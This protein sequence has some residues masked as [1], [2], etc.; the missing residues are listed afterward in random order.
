MLR[1]PGGFFDINW[2]NI[3]G[4]RAGYSDLLWKRDAA[5][6][7]YG[8][9][10][11]LEMLEKITGYLSE[12]DYIN[13]AAMFNLYWID[14]EY[15]K[16]DPE[17]TKLWDRLDYSREDI[18][19][20]IRK[21]RKIMGKIFEIYRKLQDRGQIEI[22]ASPYSHPMLSLLA[23]F[24]WEDDA[25][26]HIRKGIELYE[27][28][29]VAKPLGMWPPELAVNEASLRLMAEEG[30]IWT[31]ADMN[32]LQLAGIDIDDPRNL[33]IPYEVDLGNGKSIY[34]FFRDTPLSNQVSFAY[35]GWET[36]RAVEDF[37][38]RLLEV[39]KHNFDGKMTFTIALDGENPWE[40]YPNNANDFLHAL[41]TELTE[42]QKN[43]LIRTITPREYLRIFTVDRVLPKTEQET[44]DLKDID[45]SDIKKYEDLPRTRKLQAIPEGTWSGLALGHMIWIGDKQEDVAWMWLKAAR[46]TFMEFMKTHPEPEHRPMIKSAREALYLAQT[47]CWWF[48]YSWEMG[49]PVTFDPLFKA[50]LINIYQRLGEGVP[51]YLQAAFFPDGEPH[52]LMPVDPPADRMSASIDGRPEPGEWDNSALITVDGEWIKEVQVGYNFENLYIRVNPTVDLKGYFGEN[53]FIGVY[54]SNPRI[55]YSPFNIEYN[56]A[57]R[58]QP[59]LNKGTAG[60]ALY[61]ELGVWFDKFSATT[62]SFTLSIANG[63]EGWNELKSLQ[64]IAIDE[65]L[66]LSVPFDDLGL[67]GGD[68]IYLTIT[69][70]HEWSLIDLT[71]RLDA[72][73]AF[74]VP[75]VPREIELEE[76]VFEMDD[77]EG[78][79][80]GPGTYVYALN[81]VFVS[82]HLDL[83]RFQVGK[84]GEDAVFV[85]TFK[86]LGGNPWRGPNGFSMQHIHVYIDSDR[87]A[88]SGKTDTFGLNLKVSPAS[89]WEYALKIGPGWEEPGTFFSPEFPGGRAGLMRIEVEGETTIIVKI[90]LD[91]VEPTE[92]WAYT[93]AVA[94]FDGF[95]PDAIRPFGVEAEEWTVGGADPRAVIAGVVPRVF[96]ILVPEGMKQEDVLEG[97]DAEKRIFATLYAVGVPHVAAPALGWETISAAVAFVI[98]IVIGIV[99]ALWKFKRLK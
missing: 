23:S 85:F 69:A 91:V 83:L 13:L 39:Q 78:D 84:I 7:L 90:L 75:S 94:P 4:K 99:V 47:S 25:R 24:G 5:F 79:D 96:D 30:I 66:E 20:A 97:Y 22:T 77:P 57:V 86:T 74:S 21:Q 9:L 11:H 53:L 26:D 45:I 34:V 17:L 41:Y 29:F 15:I 52:S 19:L 27:R 71:S 67:E 89:A 3:V 43:G 50:N 36:E 82:G 81:K 76:T 93:V 64:T 62:Q 1:V 61:S 14:P 95:G 48:W 55:S 10:P 44:L 2:R 63:I 31:C 40:W 73:F 80:H 51:A 6:R 46:D 58:F 49:S 87:V 33:H 42:L 28:F 59:S 32:I 18:G 16:A 88:G 72:P 56:T 65:I 12:Q 92:K 70:A 8:H 68:Q 60:F 37:V 35:S 54:L 98:V 38:K